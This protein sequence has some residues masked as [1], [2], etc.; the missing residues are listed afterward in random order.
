M[1]FS[2]TTAFLL[3]EKLISFAIF[4]ETLELI[5]MRSVMAEN[6]VWKWSTV[7]KD[8]EIFS[9][10]TQKIFDWLL[11]YR[12]FLIIL[13][14]RL[15]AAFFLFLTPHPA[16]IFILFLSTVLGCLRWR[17]TIHGGS[18]FMTLIILMALCAASL[19]EENSKMKTIFL[20]YI[21]IQ[22]CTSYFIAGMIKLKKQN[23]RS[24]KA[25]VGIINSAIYEPSPG[26]QVINQV[27]L[28]SLVG[29]WTVM[30]LECSFPLSLMNSKACIALMA[31]AFV[32]HLA[33]GFVLGL[34]RFLWAWCA[35]YPALYYCSTL[36]S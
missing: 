10:T 14:I 30:V 27:P 32:F 19:F 29:S 20:W 2:A 22:I 26:L 24:G 31:L 34:N 12:H 15:M 25:L 11:S 4:F 5:Q 13:T 23:W 7:K 35:A 3:I 16:F 1:N 33:N 8:F 6:G 28:L 18:D 21:A 36:Q 17:G 9:K